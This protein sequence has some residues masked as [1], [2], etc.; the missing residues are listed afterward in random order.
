M[1]SSNQADLLLESDNGVV[2]V[3]LNRPA[4]RNALLPDQLARLQEMLGD[5]A[6]DAS[7][8]VVVIRGSGGDAFCAGYE[9]GAIPLESPDTPHQLLRATMAAIEGLPVPVIAMIEGICMGAGCEL[10]AACDIRLCNDKARIGMPPAK[11]GVLYH[12][13]GLERFINLVGV[14]W[15]KY[16]FLT[17]RS[18]DA[19]TAKSI[20][21]VHEVLR[22]KDLQAYTREFAREM[23]EENAPLS[24]RG[25]KAMVGILANHH[26]LTFGETD[27][28]DEWI[29]RCFRSEDAAEG[30]RA[31]A[32]KRK[33]RFRGQ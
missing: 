4:K 19:S 5:L 8:R 15:T 24:V 25:A 9:V 7:C 20:G 26:R 3:T 22:E 2:S 27:L 18:V 12:P 30:R 28:M 33:P 11:L 32:E 10:A 31:F 23:A 13:T 14:G 17:G 6:R 21:L 1:H 16:L 29:G